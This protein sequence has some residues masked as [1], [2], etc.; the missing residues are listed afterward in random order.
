MNQWS[1]GISTVKVNMVICEWR[2]IILSGSPL[3]GLLG[4]FR[5]LFGLPRSKADLI[6][7]NSLAS[8]VWNCRR[9]HSLHQVY[10]FEGYIY[11]SIQLGR[12]ASGGF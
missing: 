11:F 1:N 8:A 4:L 5:I 6:S 9:S 3:R 10:R 12:Y 7:T 2:S